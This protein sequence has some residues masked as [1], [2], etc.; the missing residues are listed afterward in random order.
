MAESRI[1]SATHSPKN[2]AAAGMT[3]EEADAVTHQ[4][5]T[6][7]EAGDFDGESDAGSGYE[8]D[9]MSPGPCCHV[10]P[11]YLSSTCIN[12]N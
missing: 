9:S 3:T 11:L 8:S 5:E 2:E 4:A 7:I 12:A 6:T 10:Q 1:R